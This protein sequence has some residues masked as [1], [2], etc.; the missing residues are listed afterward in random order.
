MAETA[1]LGSRR[2]G[3]RGTRRGAHAKTQIMTR[4]LNKTIAQARTLSPDDR[5]RITH[6]VFALLDGPYELGAE[7]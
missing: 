6:L 7:R 4:L 3:R 1:G 2:P 5:D